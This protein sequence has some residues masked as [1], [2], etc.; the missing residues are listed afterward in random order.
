MTDFDCDICDDDEPQDAPELTLEDLERRLTEGLASLKTTANRLENND[1]R[2]TSTV[3]VQGRNL[4]TKIEALRKTFEE[5]LDQAA[6]R[7]DYQHRANVSRAI[8]ESVARDRDLADRLHRLELAF[9]CES[10]ALTT[11]AGAT[12]LP[13]LD[14]LERQLRRY[15]ETL[16]EALEAITEQ[17]RR[18]DKLT[19][20]KDAIKAGLERTAKRIDGWAE[21]ADGWAERADAQ[22]AARH[23]ARNPPQDR[24]RWD[25]P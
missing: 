14:T 22:A 4:D 10:P 20:P 13:K 24:P 9:G 23:A 5:A 18:L 25:T 11:E 17:R 8:E 2:R 6:N 16:L 21:R 19:K 1:L 15:S 12:H 3:N 7:S